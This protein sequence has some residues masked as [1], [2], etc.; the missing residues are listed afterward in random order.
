MKKCPWGGLLGKRHLVQRSVAFCPRRGCVH[1]AQ[2]VWQKA[3]KHQP[4][5]LAQAVC[6]KLGSNRP[7]CEVYDW[8]AQTSGRPS[9]IANMRLHVRHYLREREVVLRDSD[10]HSRCGRFRSRTDSNR[11][12]ERS[13]LDSPFTDM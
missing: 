1:T 13:G 10:L 11:C 9:S 2:S 7:E 8:L 5:R 3:V 12:I 4:L 6:D